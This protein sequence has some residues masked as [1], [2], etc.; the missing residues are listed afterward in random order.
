MK[1]ERIKT[2][3]IRDTATDATQLSC[4]SR[5]TMRKLL[6]FV[7]CSC[8]CPGSTAHTAKIA[9]PNMPPVIGII[10]PTYN[11][12]DLLEQLHRS[13]ATIPT[14]VNWTHYVIDDGSDTDY[15]ETFLRCQKLSGR[16]STERILNSG[17]L[18]ARN[19]AIDKAI[20]DGCTHLCFID[21]D[22]K[23]APAGLSSIDAR[24]RESS[25]EDW[26][27]FGSS[28]KTAPR[29]TWPT[30]PLSASWFDDVVRR[31][32]FGSDNL[33]V[34]SSR[35]IGTTRFSTRGRNQRE[36]TFFLDVSRKHDRVLVCP[37]TLRQV[38]YQEGGLTDQAR[39]QL[40]S[41]E[42][43][44]N[45]LERAV[46]Y[47]LRRPHAKHLLANAAKQTLLTPIKLAHLYM[48][49]SLEKDKPVTTTN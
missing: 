37:E 36:W 17:P 9:V 14:R 11:R 23:L 27:L 22:D 21:D 49:K 2:Q 32:S 28:N 34:L 48:S 19:H 8:D 13:I 43:I 40:D 12:P 38:T 41:L 16:L 46:R 4:S 24:L 42:Q 44:L 18:I 45:N 31:R 15:T 29:K 7:R 5:H 1:F 39:Q 30:T 33:V 10:S 3:G 26:F 25:D 47:W 35:I 6:R 20:S